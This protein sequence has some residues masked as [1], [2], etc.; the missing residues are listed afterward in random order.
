M[1]QKQMIQREIQTGATIS[2]KDT[3]RGV[4]FE[5]PHDDFAL[6]T[7]NWLDDPPS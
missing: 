5:E 6:P 3:Q 4:Y 2:N 1:T 7:S